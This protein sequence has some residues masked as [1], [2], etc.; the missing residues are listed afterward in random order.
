LNYSEQEKAMT[1]LSY[2]LNLKTITK[3]APY[4]LYTT[5]ENISR[6]LNLIPVI[7]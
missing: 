7:C 5:S 6:T 2:K 4:H 1:S 3:K